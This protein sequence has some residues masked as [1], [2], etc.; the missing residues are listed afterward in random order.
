MISTKD[1][2]LTVKYVYALLSTTRKRKK[3]ERFR[4]M[5]QMNRRNL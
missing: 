2:Y 5:T 3:K 1:T 4:A